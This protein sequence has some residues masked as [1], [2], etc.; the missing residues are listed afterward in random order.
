MRLTNFSAIRLLAPVLLFGS[1][2]AAWGSQGIIPAGYKDAPPDF[3]VDGLALVSSAYGA[4]PGFRWDDDNR[5]IRGRVKYIEHFSR[6]EN[7]SEPQKEYT[8]TLAGKN[9]V[10]SVIMHTASRPGLM[11]LSYVDDRLVR[12][13]EDDG[14]EVRY[15]Y[16][17]PDRCLSS[18][19]TKYA[20]ALEDGVL[21]TVTR[22]TCTAKDSV[23]R[24]AAALAPGGWSEYSPSSG[25]LRKFSQTVTSLDPKSP[26]E[27]VRVVD[28]E[29]QYDS[30]VNADVVAE[31]AAGGGL[32]KIKWYDRNAK[33]LIGEKGAG[34]TKLYNYQSLDSEGNWLRRTVEWTMGNGKKMV[35]HQS[36]K[37]IYYAAGE[38]DR[39]EPEKSAEI[40]AL[41]E[42]AQA[43]NVVAQRQLGNAYVK[44]LGVIPE[45]KWA[46]H[47]YMLAAS[48]GDPEAQSALGD[49]YSDGT[50]VS[51]NDAEAEKWYTAAAIGGYAQA[52]YSLSLFYRYKNPK[53]VVK[54]VMWGTIAAANGSAEAAGSVEVSKNIEPPEQFRQGQEMAREWLLRSRK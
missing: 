31:R 34:G 23:V 9:Q 24:R 27:I 49:A 47:W 11:R 14:F 41:T 45:R 12:Q 37:L 43:G 50:F 26:G 1:G 42:K 40:N 32:I 13:W 6:G 25:E 29:R 18:V 28:L 19:V 22:Y 30:K 44:G 20:K 35:T 54:S 7:F 3:L 2:A 8:L 52:Q 39:A 33:F 51:K 15:N 36:R 53:D 16:S 38:R 4:K 5:G 48:Q 46:E 10:A 21:G 17:S